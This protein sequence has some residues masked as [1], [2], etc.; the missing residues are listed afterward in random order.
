MQ[1]LATRTS[2]RFGGPR[3]KDNALPKE[4]RARRENARTRLAGARRAQG[5]TQRGQTKE[6]NNNKKNGGV[7]SLRL[8]QA[9]GF[10]AGLAT[11]RRTINV[12]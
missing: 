3:P 1:Q 8:S 5:A 9:G 10:G 2:S 11:V 4:S 7:R 6:E 12:L